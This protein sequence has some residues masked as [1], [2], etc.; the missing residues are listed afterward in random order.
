[1]HMCQGG[2]L[3]SILSLD[4]CCAVQI[5][6]ETGTTHSPCSTRY[7]LLLYTPKIPK[8]SDGGAAS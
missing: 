2:M 6:G 8:S 5:R 7:F 4:P 3:R 1:M